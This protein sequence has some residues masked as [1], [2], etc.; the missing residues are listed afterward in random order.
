[1]T[2]TKQLQ[3]EIQKTDETV[4]GKLHLVG[5]YLKMVAKR[6]AYSRFGVEN[7]LKDLRLDYKTRTTLNTALDRAF[8][9]KK[10]SGINNIFAQISAE[11]ETVKNRK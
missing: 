2:H 3:E 6:R 5:E 9:Y 10:V 4:Y 7:L 8:F 1:M 11:M